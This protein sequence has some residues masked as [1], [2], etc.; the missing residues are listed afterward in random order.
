MIYVVHFF[1]TCVYIL[2]A[3]LF[4]HI[5]SE[6]SVIDGSISLLLPPTFFFLHQH[7]QIV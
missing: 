5:S 1:Y 6:L 3:P 7:G 4:S 2:S